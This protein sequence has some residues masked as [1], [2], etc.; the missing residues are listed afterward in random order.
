MSMNR[1]LAG[2]LLGLTLAAV[3]LCARA[4]PAVAHDGPFGIAMGEP[5]AEL[6]PL[7]PVQPGVSQVVHP[8]R[9]NDKLPTVAVVAFPNMGV[10][11]I[12]GGSDP[13]PFDQNGK[14]VRSL[15]DQLAATL[16]QKY[17]PPV[18]TDTCS[19][20]NDECQD[21]WTTVL[22]QKNA[23]YDYQW[24]ADKSPLPPG[25]KSILLT[26]VAY[27]EI[28]TGAVLTYFGVND[29]ACAAALAAAAAASL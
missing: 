16:T 2:L 25:V 21:F 26:E 22:R 17:G 28:R 5:L 10:C 4:A 11:R 23:Q 18:K 14:L 1:Q 9:A 13:Y 8:P 15:V 7:T 27:N 6:G 20:S 19:A 3:G 24:S 29:D 12:L